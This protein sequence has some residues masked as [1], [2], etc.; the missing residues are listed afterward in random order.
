MRLKSLLS[1]FWKWK[2]KDNNILILVALFFLLMQLAVFFGNY[3]SSSF[4]IFIWFCNHTPLF[5]A[6]AFFLKKKEIVKSL[7]NVG[8][9]AQFLWTFDFLSRLLFGFHIFGF[10]TY[11]FESGEGF[12]ILIPILIHIFATNIALYFTFKSKNP[13]IILF[14]SLIYLL[15]LYGTSLAFSDPN[16][17]LNCVHQICGA[18]DKTPD[19]YTAF[20]PLITFFLVVI[21]TYLL[22]IVLYRLYR[23]KF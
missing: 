18:V 2:N 7:I 19:W 22:Q 9:L 23:K 17:N 1:T 6:I 8:F 13:P 10:T 4:D 14:Y 11:V 5:F 16:L 3:Q 15:F 21:P 20:W 12:F